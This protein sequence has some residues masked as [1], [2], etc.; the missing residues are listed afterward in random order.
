M[1]PSPQNSYLVSIRNR[2][3]VTSSYA[4]IFAPPTVLP[5]ADPID[6]SVPIVC[7]FKNVPSENGT[8]VFEIPKEIHAVCGT[9][10][11]DTTN[12][13]PVQEIFHQAPVTCA[14]FREDGSIEPGTSLRVS[15]EIFQ[16]AFVQDRAHSVKPGTFSI[17]T[18]TDFTVAD[19]RQ[20]GYFIGICG[21]WKG[22]SSR[23]NFGFYST[24]TPKPNTI[25]YIQPRPI[26]GILLGDYQARSKFIG[27]IEDI[28]EVDF[29]RLGSDEVEVVHTE[30]NELVIIKRPVTYNEVTL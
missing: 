4:I 23:R 20:N 25:H 28:L 14:H 22:V 19:A 16:P 15:T 10:I 11:F 8:I 18:Q 24:F 3:G 17:Q 7:A 27:A 13:G 1:V 5:P 6:V 26:I 30:R 2:S 29:S 21:P 9:A 12:S